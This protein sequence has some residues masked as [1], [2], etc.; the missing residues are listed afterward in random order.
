MQDDCF[1]F[2][3]LPS[4]LNILHKRDIMILMGEIGVCRV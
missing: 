3:G 2:V 4:L 1:I